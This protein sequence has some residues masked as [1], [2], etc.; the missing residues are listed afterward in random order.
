MYLIENIKIRIEVADLT[1]N[2]AMGVLAP[3]ENFC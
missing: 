2:I 3:K 1:V